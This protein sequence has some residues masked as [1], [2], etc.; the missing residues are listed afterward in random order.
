MKIYKVAMD[1]AVD[2][3]I[4]GWDI[5]KRDVGNWLLIALLSIL[6]LLGIGLLP[7]TVSMLI[8][9][10]LPILGAG[11][12]YIARKA[13]IGHGVSMEYLFS[14]LE[15][16]ERR[17]Q[18]FMLGIILLGIMLIC[19]L[20]LAPL[21]IKAPFQQS[22]QDIADATYGAAEQ[23]FKISSI[24]FII[25][26]V[27]SVALV[28]MMFLFAPALIVFHKLDALEAIRASLCASW[29]NFGAMVLF[30]VVYGLLGILSLMTFGLGFL[31]VF[32]VVINALYMAYQE[33]FIGEAQKM[34]GVR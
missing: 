1:Q 3:Y 26:S 29:R 4:Y 27:I 13:A 19:S 34:V 2:W 28:T 15:N 25:L 30:F 8:Y 33:I 10:F 32:P 18:L 6:V 7:T 23:G 21:Q 9:F 17:K 14:I 22:L 11:L 24:V 16:A 12:F 31:I 20:I 5:F